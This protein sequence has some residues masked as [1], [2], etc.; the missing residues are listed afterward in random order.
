MTVAE[1]T[2]QELCRQCEAMVAAAR[3]SLAE[4][5]ILDL[6]GLDAEV[7]RVCASIAT[8]PRGERPAAAEALQR[9]TAELDCLAEAV[10]A[11]QAAQQ[12]TQ[13]EADERA[14]RGRA[15]QAYQT[16]TEIAQSKIVQ[17]GG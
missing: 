6:R 1:M 17:G 12:A 15:T 11:Q 2:T 7:E 16:R 9:L 4:G 10:T 3:D 14:A 8:L 13:R 5:A